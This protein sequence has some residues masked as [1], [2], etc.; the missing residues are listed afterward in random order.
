MPRV[1]CSGG[2]GALTAEL[3][4]FGHDLREV[5]AHR[6]HDYGVTPDFRSHGIVS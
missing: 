2:D 5:T 3:E 1:A 6:V 4:E